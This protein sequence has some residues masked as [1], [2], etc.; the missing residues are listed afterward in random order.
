MIDDQVAGKLIRASLPADWIIGDKT[1]AG[2]RGSRSI[3]AII[4]PPQGKP[5]LVGIYMTGSNADMAERNRAVATLGAAIV[6]VIANS[7]ENEMA[8]EA[9]ERR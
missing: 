6:R 1:G 5:W 2:E 4:R 8:P 9:S 3:I 7:I